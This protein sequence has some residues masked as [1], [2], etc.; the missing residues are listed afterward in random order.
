MEE[1]IMDSSRRC[2]GPDA[3]FFQ[4]A[5]DPYELNLCLYRLKANEDQS[6]QLTMH[7]SIMRQVDQ[8]RLQ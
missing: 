5:D 7:Q 6:W 3:F 2:S 8:L 4:F 1:L